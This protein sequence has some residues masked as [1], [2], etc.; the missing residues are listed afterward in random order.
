MRKSFIPL[1]WLRRKHVDTKACIRYPQS[2]LWQATKKKGLTSYKHTHSVESA[3]KGNGSS[4]S[5]KKILLACGKLMH[6]KSHSH[7]CVCRCMRII[8]RDNVNMYA[9]Y[10]EKEDREWEDEGKGAKTGREAIDKMLLTMSLL[11][12]FLFLL[13]V[14]GFK[15]K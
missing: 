4:S 14:N 6:G 11:G 10:N 8:S 3:R 2:A 13:F 7:H 5:N 12:C 9:Y 15:G 1:M